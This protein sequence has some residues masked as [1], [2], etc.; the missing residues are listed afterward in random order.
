MAEGV[1]E[2]FVCVAKVLKISG[3]VDGIPLQPHHRYK[4]P[5]RYLEVGR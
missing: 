5:G 2:Y 3:P 1:G 4:V